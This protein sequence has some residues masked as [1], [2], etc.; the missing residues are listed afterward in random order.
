MKKLVLVLGLALAVAIPA[1]A[2]AGD[3]GQGKT[4]LHSVNADTLGT[5]TGQIQFRDDGSTL[6]LKGHARGLDASAPAGTYFSLIYDNASVAVPTP[7]APEVCEPSA[8]DNSAIP[9]QGLTL[10]QMGLD[11]IPPALSRGL[12]WTVDSQGKGTLVATRTGDGYVPLDRFRTI[13]IRDGRIPG[14]L[15]P[16]SGPDAVAACGVESTP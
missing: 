1:V 8:F 15:G 16:G 10:A 5:V 3:S 11:G 12:V 6:T 14:P 13:S 2:L 4:R 7:G 9:G